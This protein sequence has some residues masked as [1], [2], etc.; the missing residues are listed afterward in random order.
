MTIMPEEKKDNLEEFFRKRVER[1][2]FDYREDDWKKL[3]SEL[4]GAGALKSGSLRNKVIWAGVGAIIATLILLLVGLEQGFVNFSSGINSNTEKAITR[5]QENDVS[6]DFDEKNVNSEKSQNLDESSNAEESAMKNEADPVQNTNEILSDDLIDNDSK[7]VSSVRKGPVSQE[8]NI[9]KAIPTNNSDKNAAVLSKEELPATAVQ[10]KGVTNWNEYGITG[11]SWNLVVNNSS[12]TLSFDSLPISAKM[13]QMSENYAWNFAAAAEFSAVGGNELEGPGLRTGL[14]F[15]YYVLDRLSVGIGANYTV[16]NYKAY[17]REYVP[18]KGFWKY[19]EVP[20]VAQGQCNVL[21]IPINISFYIPT[22]KGQRFFIRGGLSS[23]L[24]LKEKY[25]FEYES[26]DP[27][28]IS[29]WQGENE[30]YHFFS[31]VNFSAGF[32]QP[33]NQ[34]VSLLVEPYLNIPLTG[35]GFGNV[36]LYSTGLKFTLKLKHFKLRPQ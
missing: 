22:A 23:W 34:R 17:G 15:E 6:S 7:E 13:L 14:F 11:R 12:M 10:E 27:D 19:G 25:N 4:D 21:D 18:P 35:V 3:E 20:T 36:D 2:H 24:M 26:N 9:R 29:S 1:L 32:E 33:L 30:N 16:K 5:D 28:L 8:D 31:I